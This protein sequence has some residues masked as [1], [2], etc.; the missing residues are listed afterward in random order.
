[1]RETPVRD[2]RVEVFD[3]TRD[4]RLLRLAV[5]PDGFVERVLSTEQV[6]GLV[7]GAEVYRYGSPELR[8]VQP[9]ELLDL[10]ERLFEFLDGPERALAAAFGDRPAALLRITTADDRLRQLP[11]E[12]LAAGGSFLGV[13]AVHRFTP[14]RSV[15]TVVS[16][17]DPAVANR[18]L[19]VLFMAT[20]PEGVEPEL[21]FEDE[22]ARIL[23]ATSVAG[24]ELVVEEGGSL[25]GLR[26]VFE[27]H[28]PGHFDVLHLSGH[29]TIDGN[30]PLFL[31]ED[32][33][34]GPSTATPEQL[35]QAIGG[36][37]PRLVFVSGCMT[38]G[39]PAAGALPSMCEQLVR[40]GAP[41]V[42]GW[43]LPVIDQAATLFAE[44]LYRAL[45]NGYS[46][47]QA[48]AS[49]RFELYKAGGS[50]WHLLRL[51]ADASP[52]TPIV[53]PSGHRGRART[54]I[55]PAAN[56]FLDPA[57]GTVK[58]ASRAQF[59]GRR[60]L[61]Q[62]GLRTLRAPMS[63]PA[64][65]EGLVLVG[66]GGLGK[67]TLASRLVE[68]M[69]AHQRTV[70]VG[71]IDERLLGQMVSRSILVPE[72]AVRAAEI[73]NAPQLDL[74][75]RIKYLFKG[76]LANMQVLF[77]LD[78]FVH[79]LEERDGTHVCE[80]EAAAILDALLRAIRTSNSPSR[81]IVTS[82]YR[83]PEPPGTHLR[84]EA[85]ETLTRV[86]L[87][88]K[89]NELRNLRPDAPNPDIRE[90]AIHAANGTPRLLEWLDTSVGD[91]D[92]DAPAMIA[93]IEDKAEEFREDVLAR[94]LLEAQH[95]DLRV[96]LA[97][98]NLVELPIPRQAV[99]AICDDI[100]DLDQHLSRATDL[101]LIEAGLEP[102]TNE[103]RF[104]VSNILRPLLGTVLS[105][106]DTKAA[107]AAAAR[108]LYELWG[109]D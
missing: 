68:R 10:G 48:V 59:V 87:R 42:L 96:A 61:I 49:A 35:A 64:S 100:E 39:A 63:D 13:H 67:S 76:P 34:G 69:P 86:E 16:V 108:S 19:R 45:A 104:Y 58:V 23:D 51:Y 78:D 15:S 84:F 2:V 102:T 7:A 6:D 44:S 5:E 60:R 91:P 83:F 40:A 36:R 26:Y 79:N 21:S 8:S 27:T 22:E 75:E 66:M 18:P 85:L 41:L 109:L 31:V 71:R 4:T 33:L 52:L 46:P 82:R 11:W 94:V 53:T 65:P 98:I 103:L 88:K 72:E 32:E 43:A 25:E 89:L 37:W 24:S 77:V 97:R 105:A 55:L 81:I 28:G 50:D 54:E 57:T 17:A 74:R 3:Q 92:L 62:R 29:A 12:V 106:E 9:Q 93:A 47:P 56:D 80:P 14:L 20:S 90:R 107:A 38:G 101:G 99:D 70:H 1:V 95:P 73:L 30:Q